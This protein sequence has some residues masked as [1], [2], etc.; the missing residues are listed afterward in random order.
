MK[1]KAEYFADLKSF[2]KET[3][4]LEKFLSGQGFCIICGHDDLLDLEYHHVGLERNSSDFVV[5]C[6]RNCH[7][8]FSRRQRLWPKASSRNDNSQNDKDASVLL[9]LSDVLKERATSLLQ[10]AGIA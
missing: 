9:G 8:R 3:K 4:W 5:S 7:G 10:E 6:C 1:T 2:M